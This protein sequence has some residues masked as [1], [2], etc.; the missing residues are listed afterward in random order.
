[1]NRLRVLIADDHDEVRRMIVRLLSQRFEITGSVAN[2]KQLVE[3]A[4]TLHPDVIVSDICMPLVS[5]PEAMRKLRDTGLNIPFVLISAS[6]VD[7][8]K[9]VADGATAFVDKTDMG[10]ELASAIRAASVGQV[11]FSQ[12]VGSP[13]CATAPSLTYQRVAEVH[14]AVLRTSFNSC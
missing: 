6:S 13:V 3:A 14:V 1:M 4:L 8:G 7:A 10:Y 9:H 5:G 12:S 11:Y 2:G